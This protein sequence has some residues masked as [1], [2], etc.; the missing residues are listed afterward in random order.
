MSIQTKTSTDGGFQSVLSLPSALIPVGMKVTTFSGRF[1]KSN[2]G[3]KSFD[4]AGF[5]DAVIA[6]KD[7]TFVQIESPPGS[8]LIA[9]PPGDSISKCKIDGQDVLL[10][11]YGYGIL[12][13]TSLDCKASLS[14]ATAASMPNVANSDVRAMVNWITS[15]LDIVLHVAVNQSQ[16]I[17]QVSTTFTDLK[18]AKSSGFAD[19]ST[20]NNG[21]N[22]SWEYRVVFASPTS[23]PDVFE[24]IVATIVVSANIT[25]E[26]SWRDSFTMRN[27]RS[28]ITAMKISVNKNFS[29]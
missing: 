29:G 15:A 11:G 24:S 2:N 9:P 28:S 10:R 6:N 8:I 3:V 14:K 16:L 26:S 17:T 1:V 18:W 22:S 7:L 4:W 12:E 23:S 20:S 27:F 5:E 21:T 25:E 13:I 19:F